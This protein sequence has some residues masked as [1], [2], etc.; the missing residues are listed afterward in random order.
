MIY[1]AFFPVHGIKFCQAFDKK[2]ALAIFTQRARGES[3][4]W[5]IRPTRHELPFAQSFA[6][7]GWKGS[8]KEFRKA[9][10]D[11]VLQSI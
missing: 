2:Q 1:A 4:Q 10:Q 3:P 5:V 6:R 7:L 11:E 9:L 8:E